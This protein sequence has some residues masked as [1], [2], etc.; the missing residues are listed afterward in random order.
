VD[1]PERWDGEQT[2]QLDRRI[3][4]IG[5]TLTGTG[6]ILGAGIYVLVGE[7]AGSA[8]SLVW[9][10][11]VIGAVV[12]GATGLSYVELAAMFPEAG[13]SSAYAQEAWG[14]RVGF[15]VGWLRIT[16]GVVGAAAVA[17]GFGGY[18]SDLLG[19]Q[20]TGVAIVLLLSCGVI[21]L[22][23]IRETVAV[24]ITMT[25]VE[26][27]GLLFVIA[28]GLPDIGNRSL[29]DSPQGLGGVLAGTALV[30]F[31]FEGFEQIA[32]LSEET[33]NPVRSIPVAIV[34]SIAFTAVVYVLVAIVAVSV[35]AW[36][37]L[38]GTDA[39][40][41]DV[42]AAA[43]GDRAGGTLSTIALFA[44]ANTALML[45]A[46]PARLIYGMARRELVPALLG[47]VSSR[48]GS[49]WVA[50]TIVTGAALLFALQGNIGFLAQVTN[51]AVFAAFAM[52]NATVIRLRFTQAGRHRPVSVPLT[53]R[54]VPLPAVFAIA[55]VGLLALSMD[56]D[57]LIAGVATLAVGLIAS[58]VALRATAKARADS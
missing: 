31:A 11:F 48:R 57:A 52:V 13:A 33:R 36:P 4:P 54:R 56:L 14:A 43:A 16:V 40:L 29:L 26:V 27:G 49:P 55:S 12:A 53:V 51:F 38:A 47:R 30:F 32:T 20:S 7:A 6:I 17:S 45:L 50:G 35:L 44:T 24:A 25:L 8:G 18:L 39:P 15:L 2:S 22:L 10:S 23:G 9:L 28:V 34:A 58:I 21:I 41:A 42:V 3:G 37:S 1:D 19:W 5:A 46:A